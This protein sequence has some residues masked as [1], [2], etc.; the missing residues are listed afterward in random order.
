TFLLHRWH[1]TGESGLK[2]MVERTLLGMAR[3][4][5]HDQLG[6]GFHRYS[7]D[8]RWTVPHF[9][10]M[11]YDNAGLLKA[12]LDGNSALGTEEFAEVARGIVRWVREVI[13]DPEGGYAA[14]QDADVGL[15]DDGD[16]F[17]W[18]LDEATAVLTEDELA[19]AAA[20]YDI[21]TAGEMQ[22]HPGKNV[23]FV[24]EPLAAIALRL[25]R[26]AEQAAQ[27]LGSARS[28]L[29]VARD[30]RPAP[31]VDRTRYTGWNAM[32]AGALCRA[33]VVLGD[34]WARNHALLTLERIRRESPEPDAIPHTPGGLGGLLDDQVQAAQAAL[35]AHEVTGDAGWLGWAER[36]MHRVWL[37]YWDQEA[38]GLF[39]TARGRGGE[40]LLPTRAKPVQDAPTPSGNGVAAL[41]C[42]RLHEL[43]GAVL[44]ADRR[45]QLVGAIAGRA[46]DL[47]LHGATLLLAVDWCLHPAT[48]LVVTGPEGDPRADAMHQ[49]AMATFFPRRVVQRPH[50]PAST[51]QAIPPALAGMVAAGGGARG[52]ACVGATCS[53]PA[54]TEEEWRAVLEGL[55]GGET[56]P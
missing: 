47:G 11:L 51:G 25:G 20:Y 53:A 54:G 16:Y 19:V 33:G 22:H 39:D 14:S 3:G 32:M 24:A 50:G 2:E 49:R 48:H 31:F 17:T 46:G 42:A 38:G 8:A 45:D 9:E 4:G 29:R 7:V 21:G 30:L 12:Y 26:S 27:L 34:D 15:D 52:Y 28:K 56:V 44:W 40:G 1:A 18:T 13:A 55:R 36:L 43:T 37:D 35:E 5:I 23:L 6:G 41:L 10:K